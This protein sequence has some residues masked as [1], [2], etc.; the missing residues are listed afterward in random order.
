MKAILMG[1]ISILVKQRPAISISIR[2]SGNRAEAGLLYGE[3]INN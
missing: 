3:H 2:D 1:E